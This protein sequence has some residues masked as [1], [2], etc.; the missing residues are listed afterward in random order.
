[1]TVARLTEDFQGDR[2]ITGC[3]Y[4]SLLTTPKETDLLFWLSLYSLLWLSRIPWDWTKFVELSVVRGN[5]IMTYGYN[6][7][8]K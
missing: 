2:F 6:F 5:Q 4:F 7:W 8:A 1:M 3:L